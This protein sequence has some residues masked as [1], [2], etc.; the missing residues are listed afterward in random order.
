MLGI[1]TTPAKVFP[2]FVE[3]IGNSTLEGRKFFS[4]YVEPF[5]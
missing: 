4:G 5:Q 1:H 2:A 3:L